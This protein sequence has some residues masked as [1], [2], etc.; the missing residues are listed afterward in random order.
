M[1]LRPGWMI[2]MEVIMEGFKYAIGDEPSP[3]FVVTNRFISP[4]SGSPMYCVNDFAALFY[5]DEVE[6]LSYDQ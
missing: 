2:F 1:V 6:G 3:G 5:E 4:V